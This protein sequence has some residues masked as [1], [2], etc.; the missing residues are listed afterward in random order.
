METVKILN[1]PSKLDLALA[2][3]DPFPLHGSRRAFGM[4]LEGEN[5]HRVCSETCTVCIYSV[6][7]AE[8]SYE[9]D[10]TLTG[11]C[12]L[13]R[14]GHFLNAKSLRDTFSFSASFNTKTRK[15]WMT[16]HLPDIA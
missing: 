7:I 11:D 10:Y 13:Q 1:G 5:E 15:G 2:I 8:R 4:S 12:T 16:V 14:G 3:V 6:A 9:E